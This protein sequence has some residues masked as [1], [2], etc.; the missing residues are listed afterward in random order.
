MLNEPM[1]NLKRMAKQIKSIIC[2]CGQTKQKGKPFCRKCFSSLNDVLKEGLSNNRVEEFVIA[3]I[4]A[5]A[6]LQAANRRNL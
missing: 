3:Y 1:E 5:R 2:V 4:A 6:N